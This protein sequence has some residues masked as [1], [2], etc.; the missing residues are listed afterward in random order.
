L[1]VHSPH[2]DGTGLDLRMGLKVKL[3]RV[4]S[5]VVFTE[6]LEHALGAVP[7]KN[8]HFPFGMSSDFIG[9]ESLTLEF[10]VLAADFCTQMC[11]DVL[12]RDVL[13]K[14]E[15]TLEATRGLLAAE[16]GVLAWSTTHLV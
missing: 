2:S 5:L 13:L 14:R 9:R 6:L 12:E 11:R 1:G 15:M 10:S 16:T 3:A 7:L 4:V 8:L